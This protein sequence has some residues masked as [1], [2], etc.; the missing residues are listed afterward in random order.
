M[1]YTSPNINLTCNF[2]SILAWW[3]FVFRNQGYRISVMI[4]KKNDYQ[5]LFMV[6]SFMNEINHLQV[7]Q[8]FQTNLICFLNQSS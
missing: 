6:Y 3:D 1:T 5:R 8:I 7:G 4:H 2:Q